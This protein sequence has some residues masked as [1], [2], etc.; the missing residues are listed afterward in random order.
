MEYIGF[1]H[2]NGALVWRELN[3]G[4]IFEADTGEVIWFST[5]FTPTPIMLH[6]VTRGLSGKLI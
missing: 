6:R 5:R 1:A 3:G 4:W 2:L